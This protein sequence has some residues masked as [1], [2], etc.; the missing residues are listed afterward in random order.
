MM[1]SKSEES[2][3]SL[4]Q[5]AR[6]GR[7]ARRN[8]PESEKK[9]H[10]KNSVEKVG[11]EAVC[12]C[13]CARAINELNPIKLLVQGPIGH[14]DGFVSSAG[15]LLLTRRAHDENH[16][17][18]STTLGNEFAAFHAR[19]AVRVSHL[20][21]LSFWYGPVRRSHTGKEAEEV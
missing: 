17:F 7:R 13:V 6:P 4:A 11:V 18:R 5:H 8:R 9:S 16:I 15:A 19:T 21:A 3:N 14:T 1:C 12:V 2:E 10:H 20:Y